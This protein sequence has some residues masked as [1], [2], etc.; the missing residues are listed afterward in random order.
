[1][2]VWLLLLFDDIIR[3]LLIWA[4]WYIC[5]DAIDS[6]LSSFIDEWRHDESGEK[7]KLEEIAFGVDSYC[8]FEWK[9]YCVVMV[10]VRNIFFQLD[11]V[12]RGR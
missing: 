6:E 1:M 11:M 8:Y 5:P 12:T 4:F 3:V 10:V 9:I 2:N 7:K